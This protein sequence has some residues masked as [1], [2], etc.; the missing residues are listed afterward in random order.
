VSEGAEIEESAW[1]FGGSVS[2]SQPTFNPVKPEAS[3]SGKGR[4]PPRGRQVS[5]LGAGLDGAHDPALSAFHPPFQLSSPGALELA[6]RAPGHWAGSQA[7]GGRVGKVGGGVLHLTIPDSAQAEPADGSKYDSLGRGRLGG[8][9]GGL[10]AV[11]LLVT[12]IADGKICE[13]STTP[14]VL[15]VLE[16]V[17]RKVSKEQNTVVQV[18]SEGVM[19]LKMRVFVAN[20]VEAKA[21]WEYISSHSTQVPAPFVVL[22][23]HVKMAVS[24]DATSL[25]PSQA[26]V[27]DRLRK[28]VKTHAVKVLREAIGD[29]TC[30]VTKAILR[31]YKGPM[32]PMQH[33]E[34][35]VDMRATQVPGHSGQRYI[36]L[37]AKNKPGRDDKAPSSGG[38]S[39]ARSPR[40]SAPRS[41]GPHSA[42][43][44]TTTTPKGTPAHGGGW[45]ALQLPSTPRSPDTSAPS[46]PGLPDDADAQG[47][48]RLTAHFAVNL[49]VTAIADGDLAHDTPP[50][51]QERL[52]MIVRKVPKEQNTSVEVCALPLLVS[53]RLCT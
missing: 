39:A 1:P 45:P 18:S 26:S 32:E 24:Y 36:V 23:R 30:G 25:D 27:A 15:A 34:P 13:A 33:I 16:Q 22:A 40:S 21:V 44:S 29:E 38:S 19:D 20:S 17:R 46:T 49:F 6:H 8:D 35:L 43:S 41:G 7:T 5:R 3:G 2:T 50:K 11:H 10:F 47:H 53:R 51:V 37:P 14:K 52:N 4:G 28:Q 12:A 31:G 48:S 42:S 9:K